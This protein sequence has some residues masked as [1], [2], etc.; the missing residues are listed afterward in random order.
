MGLAVN[1]A[2]LIVFLAIASRRLTPEDYS[3]LGVLWALV[4]GVGNG[5]MQPL[6]QE[7]ARA[8]SARRARGIGAGPVIRRAVAL[9]AVFA[10]GV[11]TLV[12]V[13]QAFVRRDTV[14][15][16]LLVA[17]VVGLLAFCAGHL[18][19]GV[20]SSHHRFGAYA[21]FFAT[22]GVS[23]VALAAALAAAGISAVGAY[24]MLFAVTPFLGIA[25]A[26]ARPRGLLQEGPEAS[27]KE[28]T[29]A[30]GWL[31]LG[32]VSLS[33][34]IQGGTIAVDWLAT[35][36]QRQAAG[37]FLNGLQTARIPL[38]LFQAILASLLPKLSRLASTGAYA[39]FERALVRLVVAILSVGLVTTV[40][41]A[42]VGP[43][44]IDLAFGAQAAL[45]S[46]DLALLAIAFVVVMAA[47]CLDQALVA[48]SSH[49]RMALGWFVALGVF[50]TVTALGD[51]LYLRVELGLLAGSLAAMLWMGV[52]V[53][54]L[55]RHHARGR[56]L[57]LSEAMAELP[58]QQ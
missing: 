54:V 7:V 22:D 18:T 14:N 23:R 8:V 28:L 39:D 10:A 47:I 58:V 24:G 32:T 31:L 37:V 30:L 49:S 40:V 4:F 3:A 15:G 56:A 17:F 44:F 5:I 51:D 9:G 35:A 41:A 1:G 2:A 55:L 42:V 36:D 38:F 50:V 27:W 45:T 21:S 33:L 13:G 11:C 6:E 26:L 29:T 53:A 46:R 25:V 34:L 12:L 43:G 52:H 57:D 16:W 19:R 20:L 48:L